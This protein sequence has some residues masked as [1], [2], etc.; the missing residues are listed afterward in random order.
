MSVR[1]APCPL[2]LAALAICAASACTSP[3]Y[4]H[5]KEELSEG[6]SAGS[7]G[8]GEV[9]APGQTRTCYSGPVGTEGKGICQA[10]VETCNAE[11]TAFESCQ[12]E[13]LPQADDCATP[14]DED[15]DGQSLPCKGQLLW[16]KR[17]GD[18]LPNVPAP[19]ARAAAIAISPSGDVGLTGSFNA[20]LDFG[21]GM[22]EAVGAT[23]TYVALLDTDGG[24][25]RAAQFG[26]GNGQGGTTIGFDAS[27]QLV[28]GGVFSGTL[29]LG[30]PLLACAGESDLYLG[31]FDAAGN[32]RW[33]RAF[34]DAAPQDRLAAAVDPSGSVLITGAFFGAVDLGGGLLASAGGKD[35]FVAKLSGSGQHEWSKRFGDSKYQEPLGVATDPDG[36]VIV[37]GV[38]SG[39]VDFGL[40]PLESAGDNDIFLAKLSPEG[41]ALWAKRFGDEQTQQNA[42]VAVDA[43]G[44]ILL[45]GSFSGTVNLGGQDLESDGSYD[46]F[47]AKLDPSGGHLWSRRFGNVEE[48]LG[49]AVTFDPS[50][51]VLLAGYLDGAADFGGGPLASAGGDDVFLAKLDPGGNHLWSKRFGDAD[52]QRVTAIATDAA[53]AV[54]ITGNFAGSI[55]FGAGSLVAKSKM[56]DVFV[57]KLS[58]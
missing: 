35:G 32:H 20:R 48:Q 9:C 29:A 22:L 42:V 51:N 57:A 41:G 25:V 31:A 27:E 6:G 38:F 15:C 46:V 11:G 2:T 17:F 56:S 52:H 14:S 53:G 16:A 37:T 40:G 58:P 30:G 4:F 21:G 23:D 24:Y 3:M 49:L 7:S 47:L 55:D 12:G 28:T 39:D 43:A 45:A 13:H 44:N 8:E 50:G 10:G 33:S 19:A 26:E 34:G 54:F 18:L 1:A 5:S 36:N